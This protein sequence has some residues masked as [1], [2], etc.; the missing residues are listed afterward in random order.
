MANWEGITTFLLIPNTA[1][2]A[3][4]GIFYLGQKKAAARYVQAAQTN[5]KTLSNY[6]LVLIVHPIALVKFGSG[7]PP[8]SMAA[9]ASST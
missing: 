4:F 9:I 8:F 2:N 5:R 7:S 3:E 6:F 1:K